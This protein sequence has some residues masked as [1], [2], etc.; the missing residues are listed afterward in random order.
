MGWPELDHDVDNIVQV[1][2]PDLDLWAKLCRKALKGV[3]AVDDLLDGHTLAVNP[4]TMIWF[5]AEARC[6]T[7]VLHRARMLDLVNHQAAHVPLNGAVNVDRNEVVNDLL[8]E[9]IMAAV[10]PVLVH[11][12]HVGGREEG[13][14]HLCVMVAE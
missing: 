14:H 1:E 5:V 13:E 11:L 12:E 7:E 4:E 9:D 6:D 8:D 3:R 10:D 2:R